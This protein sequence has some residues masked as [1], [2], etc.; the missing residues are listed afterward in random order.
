[1]DNLTKLY[2]VIDDFCKKYEPEFNASLVIDRKQR[3]RRSSCLSLAELMTLVVLFHQ[4]RYRQ[5]KSFYLNHVCHYL[6]VEFP[7]LPSYQRCVELLPRCA[8]AFCALFETLKGQCTG[9]SIVGSTPLAVCNNL[10]IRCHRVFGGMAQRGESSTGWFFGFKLHV[11][12][13]HL[14]ELLSMALLTK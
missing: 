14:G 4:I 9:L 12:I 13:T 1:M 6:K 2:C 7:T 3:R 11:V 10:R 8:Y 5:F